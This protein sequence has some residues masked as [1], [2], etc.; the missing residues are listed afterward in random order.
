MKAV[1]LAGSSFLSLLFPSATESTICR[2]NYSGG[3]M[4]CEYRELDF[5]AESCDQTKGGCTC[6]Q[7]SLQK[8]CYWDTCPKSH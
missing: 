7:R 6:A 3:G 4:Q 1:P 5:D 8:G 2:G